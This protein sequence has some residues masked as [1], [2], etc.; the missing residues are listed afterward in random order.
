VTR[1]QAVLVTKSGC[2]Q[3]LVGNTPRLAEDFARLRREQGQEAQTERG[4]A[5]S[6]VPETAP[7][8]TLLRGKGCGCFCCAKVCSGCRHKQGVAGA[9][10]SGG[11]RPGER[12]SGE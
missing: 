7:W 4:R 5:L 3:A 2:A 10:R 6:E 1:E 11:G 12:L 9:R 8:N